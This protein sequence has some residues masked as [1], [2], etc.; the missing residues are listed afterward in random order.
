MKNILKVW[1]KPLLEEGERTAIYPYAQMREIQF[2]EDCRRAVISETQP[3]ETEFGESML[4]PFYELI[5]T[6]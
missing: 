1:R 3:L 4:S 6:I 2:R 5:W